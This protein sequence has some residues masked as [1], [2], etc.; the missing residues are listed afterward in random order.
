VADRLWAAGKKADALHGDK[1][2]RDRTRAVT[3]FQAG[4]VNLL[5]ATVHI[6]DITSHVPFQLILMLCCLLHRMWRRAGS[7]SRASR[8]SLILIFLVG[9]GR[10]AWRTM[11]TG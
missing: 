2:Q 6:Y 11:C 3:A 5:C 10:V 9:S 4:E 1:E 7:M 8:Q